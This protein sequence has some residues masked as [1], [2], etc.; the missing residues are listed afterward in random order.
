MYVQKM[1]CV[2]SYTLRRLAFSCFKC[3][4]LVHRLTVALG[5]GVEYVPIVGHARDGYSRGNPARFISG[6]DQTGDHPSVANS[7]RGPFRNV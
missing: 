2:A 1:T 4:K 3:T 5:G 6:C 7:S